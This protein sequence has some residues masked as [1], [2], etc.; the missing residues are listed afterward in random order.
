MSQQA[1]PHT[2]AGPIPTTQPQATTRS[3]WVGW[4]WFGGAMMI[5]L[6]FFNVIEGLVALFNDKYYVVGPQGLLV[7]DITGWG[8][9]HL[10][11]GVLA[12]ASGLALFTG[13]VWARIAA[14]FLATVNA[15]AQ[16]AFLSAYPVWATVVI[17]LDVLVIWAVIVHGDE[18]RRTS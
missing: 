15:V 7:F 4:I 1:Q 18:A 17:A 12:V 8:W 3:L 14:V 13:A 9:V 2:G 6:G 10:I 11:I 5:L 16:L